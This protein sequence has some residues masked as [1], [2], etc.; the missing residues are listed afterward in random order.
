MTG[1]ALADLERRKGAEIASVIES[2][3][4]FQLSLPDRGSLFLA[5]R[6][7]DLF[8]SLDITESVDGLAVRCLV[9]AMVGIWITRMISVVNVA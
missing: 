9:P 8:S 4:A 3:R 2:E 5:V 1:I 7:G 6:D